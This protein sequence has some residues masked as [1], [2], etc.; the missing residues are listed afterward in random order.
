MKRIGMVLI[1]VLTCV[2]VQTGLAGQED[3]LNI[4]SL[5]TLNATGS[6]VHLIDRSLFLTPGA[7]QG[8]VKPRE[9]VAGG[10]WF[11][12]GADPVTPK[13][14]CDTLPAAW[15]VVLVDNYAITCNYQ[16]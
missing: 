11:D 16:K 8:R 4:E 2:M 12:I 6:Y 14:I 9:V 3:H 7:V 15:D 5:R 1:P 13:L 10:G